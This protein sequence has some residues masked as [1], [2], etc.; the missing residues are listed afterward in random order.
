MSRPVVELGRRVS[1]RL[2]NSQGMA[3]SI[4]VKAAS[5]FHR[6]SAGRM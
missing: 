6:R 2:R 4:S 3:I 5:G 1:A